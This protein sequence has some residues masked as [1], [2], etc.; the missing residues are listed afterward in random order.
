MTLIVVIC[1]F[2]MALM[3]L[4]I[5]DEEYYWD[6]N[7]IKCSSS[8][9]GKVFNLFIRFLDSKFGKEGVILF[10]VIITLFFSIFTF[11]WVL[12]KQTIRRWIKE[13]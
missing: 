10:G 13:G 11:N 8:S 1:S 12:I 4:T 3:Y 9:K 7:C 6:I 2:I 5:P